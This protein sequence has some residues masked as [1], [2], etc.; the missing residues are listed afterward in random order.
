MG[1]A[2]KQRAIDYIDML[3]EEQTMRVI[4][5]IETLPSIKKPLQNSKSDEERKLAIAAFN[6]LEKLTRSTD[7]NISTNGKDEWTEAFW[8]KYESLS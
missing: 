6:D 4:T 8:R 1:L 7:E 3:D 2:L 5:Y